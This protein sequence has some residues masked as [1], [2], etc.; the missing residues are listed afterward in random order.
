M[1]KISKTFI[2]L[3]L[4]LIAS[5]VLGGVAYADEP[6]NDP[7]KSCTNLAEFIRDSNKNKKAVSFVIRRNGKILSSVNAD[8]PMPLASMFKWTVA[9]EYSKQVGKGLLD[10][11]EKIDLS[12]L[13]RYYI[14][15]TDGDAYPNWVSS[16]IK[17]EQLTNSQTTLREIVKG[18]IVFSSNANTDYLIQRLGVKNINKTIKDMGLTNHSEVYPIVAALYMGDYLKQGTGLSDS[19]IKDKLKKMSDKDYIAEIM[20]I[21]QLMSQ[22]KLP[23]SVRELKLLKND[24]DFQKIW[25]DRFISAT[26]NDYI[27]IMQLI[28]DGTYF[29][30]AT[31][32]EL[33]N[34]VEWTMQLP[35][36]DTLFKHDGQKG[37]ST[38]W[39]FTHARYAEQLN[40]DKTEM[41]IMFNNL[42]QED[43]QMLQT[44]YGVFSDYCI[45]SNE[46]RDKLLSIIKDSIQK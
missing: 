29:D 9:I 39:I 20:E 10:P 32:Q 46:A 11:N 16:I 37:G 33:R 17:S 28:N 45:V 44:N 12:K 21:H 43:F 1:K 15:N 40:G 25:S 36:F 8:A 31:Q 38:P 2:S 6:I 5:I 13:E 30:K 26:A 27:R 19:E 22:N 4:V 35:G 42:S 41:V 24:I 7:I 34:V 14:P 18:M 3:I 23:K